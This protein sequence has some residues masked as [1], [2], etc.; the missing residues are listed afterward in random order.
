MKP[1]S[2]SSTRTVGCA[3]RRDQFS[4]ILGC[5]GRH[6]LR[7]NPKVVS[8]YPD[9]GSAFAAAQNLADNHEAQR[10]SLIEQRG[11]IDKNLDL[12]ANRQ[13]LLGFQEYAATGDV[14]GGGLSSVSRQDV[15]RLSSD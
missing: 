4:W 15:L 12:F 11:P 3:I 6:A 9:G 14:R 8:D 10:A 2:P 5:E 1:S 7:T 13:N